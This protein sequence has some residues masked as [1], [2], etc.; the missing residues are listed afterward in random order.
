MKKNKLISTIKK[1]ISIFDLL[2]FSVLLLAI[3]FF[4][5]FFYRKAEYINIRIKVTDRDILYARNQPTAWY[6]NQFKK[7]VMERDAVGR[8]I[9]EVTNV[10]RFAINANTKAVY[11]DLKVRATYDSRTKSYTVR[12]KKMVFGAPMR[13]NLDDIT[14][15]GFVVDFPGMYQ[16]GDVSQK[17]VIVE[18]L[19]REIEPE[20]IGAIQIGDKIVNSNDELLAEVL[21]IQVSPA[22]QVVTTDRGDMLLRYDPLYKDLRMTVAVRVIES[23][24][25]L[26]V[27]DNLPLKIGEQIPLNFEKISFLPLVVDY[28]V[29]D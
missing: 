20:L 6:A 15:D 19:A 1:N 2:V 27:F 13:F 17:K 12:G 4:F 3:A 25:D 29:E 5:F 24:N 10:E 14:F 26:F 16:Q 18:V 22:E 7:G 8:I 21:D 23:Q 28:K 9:S 11:L